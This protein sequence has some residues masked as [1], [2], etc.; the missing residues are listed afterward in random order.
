[1]SEYQYYEFRAIDHPLTNK[2][3]QEV[4]SLSSR[5]YVTSHQASFVYHYGDFRGDVKRLIT[6]HFDMMLYMANWGTRRLMFR[7][8]SSLIDM[9]QVAPFCISE[10]IDHWSSK[11]KESIILDLN[12][13]DEEQSGWTEGKGWLD[14]LIH[15]REELIQG[16]FRVLYLAWLKAAEKALEMEKIDGDTLEPPVPCGLKQLS[17]AQR[18]YIRFLDIDEAMVAVAAQKSENKRRNEIKIEK[19]IDKLS[20]EEK[21]EFLFRLSLGER[22]LSLLLNRRL[23]ELAAK[24]QPYEEKK[25]IE[26]RTI[27]FLIKLVEKWRQNKKEEER[28]KAEI[29]RQ[30]KMEMLATKKNEVWEEIYMLIKEKKP[31]SYDKAVTLLNELNEL[32]QY[33]GDLQLFRKQIEKI[34]NTYSNRSALLRK[35]RSSRLIEE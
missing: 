13:C 11:D 12:F 26:R 33:Q 18:E 6:E 35:M 7:I 17:N 31:K 28:Q 32:A 23:L 15:L 14:E 22:N 16:D 25:S 3:R 29:E 2:Q 21:H 24:E 10:E 30:K 5:A 20:E 8:P 4:A 27:S 19:W 34:K 9:K 1:M